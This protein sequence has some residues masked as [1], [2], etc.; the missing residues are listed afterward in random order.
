M[1]RS[2][3]V[4]IA[5]LM[6]T[7]MAVSASATDA[8]EGVCSASRLGQP[9]PAGGVATQG[10]A[11]PALNL[12][13]GNP[14]HLVSGNKYQREVDLPGASASIGLE[15]VRHYNAMDPRGGPLGRGWT[16]SYDTRLHARDGGTRVQIAQAD[17][18]RV[19]FDCATA[20]RP[21]APGT[22]RLERA[23][24]ARDAAM[25]VAASASVRTPTPMPTQT[26]M[27]MPLP[28]PASWH[29]R[30][31]WA[32]G[33][34]LDFDGRGRLTRIGDRGGD[35]VR[36]VRAEGE[37]AYI[38]EVVDQHGE[39]L[40]F[41]YETGGAGARLAR[42]DSRYGAYVYT[43]DVPPERRAD[44]RAYRRAYRLV[45]VDHPAGWRREYAHEPGLHG[46][47]PYLLT[48][49]SWRTAP[50]RPPLRTHS[51]AYDAQGRAVLST[52]GTPESARDRVEISY[53]A[54]PSASG[55]IGLTRVHGPSGATDFHTAIRGG[56]PVLLRVEG[57]GCPGCAAPGLHAEYD[58]HG[59]ATR[60]NEL[61]FIRAADGR[62]LHLRASRSGWAGLS[63]TF[64]AAHPGAPLAAW[65]S[66]ATGQETRRHDSHGRVTERR[67]ANGD[68]WRYAY[69]DDGRPV[70]VIMHSA[71][72][73]LRTVVAW[74]G[75]TP[76]SIV[77]P[78]ERETRRHDG[79]GRLT[80]RIVHRPAL[81]AGDIAYAYREGYRRDDAGRVVRHDLPEGG[82]LTYAYD[83]SGRVSRVAWHDG[84]RKQEL[85]RAL[86]A[87]GY[88][89]GNGLRTR[90]VA[91]DGALEAL[92]VDDPS[93]PDRPPVLLQ[94]LR[95]DAAGRIVD[96]T[97]RVAGWQGAYGYGRDAQGQLLA[98][99]ATLRK[100]GEAEAHHAWRIAWRRTGD[101]YAV[102]DDAGT[103]V[104]H[105]RRDA[106]GLPTAHGDLRLR[107]GPD[108]RLASVTRGQG[109]AGA[110]AGAGADAGAGAVAGVRGRELAR[111]TH[112]AYG[113]RIRRRADGRT[114]EYL[115]ASNRLA[116]IAQPL[117]AGG[118]GVTRR[119]VYAGWVPI[120]MIVYPQPRP[121][122]STVRAGAGVN[123]RGRATAAP[124]FHAIHADAIGLPHAVTDASRR[125]R[126]RALWSPTGA[127]LATDGDLAMP[128]RQ[129]GHLHDPATGLH[130]NY[131]RT[132]DPRMGHYLEPDPA[133][134]R[135]DTQAYGYADQQPRRHID[136]F[137]L[138]LFAFDGTNRDIP[139]R[140]NVGLMRN[141]YRDGP[142]FYH[143]GPGFTSPRWV[144]AATAGSAPAI[145]ETQWAALLRH[146]AWNGQA[147][148][149]IDLLGYSRGAALALHFSNMIADHY[150]NG[151]FWV[152]DPVQGTVTACADLRFIGLFDTVAQFGFLGSGD[153]D[154]NFA[155]S[156]E[157]RWIAHAIALHEHRAV[158]PLI[159]QAER[160]GTEGTGRTNDTNGA[161]DANSADGTDRTNGTNGRMRVTAPFIGAHG[162]IGGGYLP[163]GADADTARPGGD[164]S[165]VA[166][167]WMLKQAESAGAAFLPP[168][169]A[170]QRVDNPLLHDERGRRARANNDD[171]AV[172]NAD[173]HRVVPYQG[174]HPQYG[175][176]ARA[177]VEAV[178]RRVDGWAHGGNPVVGT[179]DMAAYRAWLRRTL[180]LDI[181]H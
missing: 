166:L 153:A 71:A 119:F 95:Y 179:V 124:V 5:T 118:V 7:S 66:D 144:D 37:D 25:A 22:G 36:I 24:G 137:G 42:I 67:Y 159:V 34:V 73:A 1:G 20:C 80:A 56:R 163:R 140:T 175:D 62:L 151:R 70:E 82:Y 9:C 43:H 81:Q 109:G 90:G 3:T 92:V 29:W 101:A 178:I 122:S 157:W 12:G 64:D 63:L 167:A 49:I 123:A 158:F 89:H 21:L 19:D 111:Y 23:G 107:Y 91:R 69:D 132:Y 134:P 75:A 143:H 138:L 131:L 94:R 152:R 35:H 99:T 162:D 103:Q 102:G 127:V 14:I 54:A 112:N 126:W 84:D 48:G 145:L 181:A 141:W 15:I 173:G 155:A 52:H 33:R 98:A 46:G 31:H 51:W 93:A 79:Q 120:A 104:H 41:V 139:A 135:P 16:L 114:E 168:P 117:P 161:N 156:A 60:V 59:N 65:S 74:H 2:R 133:G 30:W 50:D 39:A 4:A 27:P 57:A 77:H 6:I 26:P 142:I 10:S 68:I 110:G 147:G 86:P 130:D 96:E 148:V 32:N 11:A 150:R 154:Y 176:A 44:R 169:A 85:L 136:P 78:H 13:A 105:P 72:G 160:A 97:L 58:A 121:L 87:G 116:A 53:V 146:V 113:E 177:E 180:D 28:T 8:A 172:G 108:R 170:F 129:P 45:A 83:A 165:D 149:A 100:D 17:G 76:T 38:T 128:L 88:R 47:D 125:L 40:R 115:Y 164:L 174:L 55:A 171:R 106:S 18:S 61:R